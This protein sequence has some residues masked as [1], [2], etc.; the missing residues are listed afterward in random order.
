MLLGMTERSFCVINVLETT[1]NDN[2]YF[3]NIFIDPNVADTTFK[4]AERRSYKESGWKEINHWD[5][6]C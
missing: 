1:W 5:F 6:C 3:L 2:D 4:G